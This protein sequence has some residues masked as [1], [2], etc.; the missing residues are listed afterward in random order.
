MIKN[1]NNKNDIIVNYSCFCSKCFYSNEKVLYILPCCHIVH[2]K[3]FN[4]YILKFQYEKFYLNSI[5]TKT[6][7]FLKCPIC[8][9]KIKNALSELKINSK[10]N[11]EYKQYQ[12]DIKSVKIDNSTN[13]NYLIL[14]L[15]LLKLIS[16]INKLITASTEKDFCTIIENCLNSFNIKINVI[17]NT[18]K[19]PIQIINNQII[20]K[21]K[22][23]NNKLIIISNHAS[24]LDSIIIYYLFRCGFVSSD[25]INHTDIGKIIAT[26]LKLLIFKRGVDTNMVSK[27]KE[28][29]NEQKKI[30]IYPEGAIV[31]NETII[32]FRT[33][34][35]FVDA[36]ICPIII[37]YKK[38]IYDDDFKKMLFKLI[39]QDEIIVDV[40]IND[41]FY[42]PF[43]NDKIEKIRD[44][45]TSVGN[46]EKSRVSNK[47]LKE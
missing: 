47:S 1:N 43:D 39:T 24:Y 23:D 15:G 2:E 41:L 7:I 34:A 30:V 33:G 21:N 12:I 42:P 44:L 13:I 27:I 3:C 45:M 9:N 36:P 25:F 38:V 19:N 37:K 11:N 46:F 4:E 35:F 17:D 18:N 10:K 32:R 20:W 16:I 22:E 8:D 40:H 5:E 14:P 26:K 29:L 6:K 28:Y 31:N